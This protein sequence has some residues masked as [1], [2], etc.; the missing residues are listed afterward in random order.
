MS[1][2]PESSPPTATPT[3]P[4][5]P[6]PAGYPAPAPAPQQGTNGLAIAGLILAFLFAPIGFILSIVGLVQARKR[7]QRGRGLAIGGIV[8]SVLAMIVFGAMVAAGAIFVSTVGKNV[9]TVVDPGCTAGKDVIMNSASMPSDPAAVKVQLQ[10]AV[11]GLNGA[12]AK[13][14]H[15]NVRNAMKALADDYNQ[16]VQALNTGT[17]PPADVEQKVATDAQQID[18]LCTIGA[19]GK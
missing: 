18:S 10:T 6:P 2:P 3:G 13:A 12:A 11:D 8:V 17:A 19:A 5:A 9:A 1:I 7:G 16:L 15:D 4:G 14:K